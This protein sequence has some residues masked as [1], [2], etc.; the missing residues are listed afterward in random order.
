MIVCK[1]CAFQNLDNDAFCG[2]CGGF[3]EWT[4]ESVVPAAAAVPEEVLAGKRSLLSRVQTVLSL[5]IQAPGENPIAVEP[6]ADGAASSAP[7][8][9]GAGPAPARPGAPPRPGG[10]APARPG[11][12]PPVRPGGGDP[13]VRPGGATAGSSGWWRS[14]GSSGWWRPPVRPGGAS[15]GSSGWWRSA[16]SSGWWRSAGASGWRRRFADEA[17]S[18]MAG[19][20]RRLRRDRGLGRGDLGGRPA[21]SAAAALVAAGATDAPAAPAAAGPPRSIAKKTVASGERVIG[22]RRTV[23]GGHAG[24]DRR[25]VKPQRPADRPRPVKQKPTRK[26]LPG[27]RICGDCGEGNPPARKFCSRCGTTLAAADVAKT[28]WWRK[29]VPH[30]RRKA[31]EAGERPWKSKDG[32]QKRRRGIGGVFM[33]LF[34]KARPLIAAALLLVGL[35]YGVSPD[36]R[37]RVN[38][39]IGDARDSV[40]SKIRKNYAPLAPIEVTATSA[41]DGSPVTLAVDSNTVTSWIAPGTDAEPTL[42]ARF[43]EPIDLERIKIWNGSAN[44]FKEHERIQAIHFVFDTGQSYDLEILDLPDGK[45]Y[46]VKNGTGIRSVEVHVVGTYS[47]LSSEDLGLSE[48]EFLI[49]R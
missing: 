17:A 10:D 26:I 43:D 15:A 49:R 7:P 40:M 30:R 36:L 42:V 23:D 28:P 45:D 29:L 6:P 33:A 27:D 8:R 38:A 31:M 14:A 39:S 32:K 5:D 20:K 12:A 22:R 2:S 37:G 46:E 9:P 1:N 34:A 21:I 11:G 16:G 4:G 18:R 24:R 41:V 19:G 25:R 35:V 44:G 13:P 47:S 48:I 3:L